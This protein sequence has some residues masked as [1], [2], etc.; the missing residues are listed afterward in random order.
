MAFN[1]PHLPVPVPLHNVTLGS[2]H[3]E[4]EFISPPLEARLAS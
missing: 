2:F 3:G 4:V 1:E